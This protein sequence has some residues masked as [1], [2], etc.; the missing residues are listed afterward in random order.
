M[1]HLLADITPVARPNLAAAMREKIEEARRQQTT[2]AGITR[3][4]VRVEEHAPL[5]FLHWLAAL[6]T[7]VLTGVSKYYWSDRTRVRETAA[8]DIAHSVTAHT[9]D[10]LARI[11]DTLETSLHGQPDTVRYFGGFRFDLNWN[12]DTAGSP[13]RTF[14]T[15][16]FVLPRFELIRYADSLL[17]AC[18]LCESDW[19]DSSLKHIFSTLDALPFVDPPVPTPA[20]TVLDRHDL[21]EFD[22]WQSTLRSVDEMFARRELQKIVLARQS[23]LTFDRPLS[24]WVLLDQL[25]AGSD[26]CYL[27]GMQ[28]EPGTAF[29]GSSPEQL[30]RRDGVRLRTEAVAGTRPRGGTT[31][32]DNRL[33]EALRTSEKDAREHRVVLEGIIEALTRLDIRYKHEPTP[34]VRS[35]SRVHH[36]TCPIIG[37][38]PESTTDRDL[39]TALHPTPAVGGYPKASALAQIR[40]L[41]PFDRGWYAGPIG[42]IGSTGAE[43]AVGIRSALIDQTSLHLFAGAGIVPGSDPESEWREVDTK[44]SRFI[45]A[46]AGSE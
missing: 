22:A 8:V 36:L 46:V 6:E 29:V 42:W 37:K 28:T 39:I 33:A 32:E 5:N 30:Y 35:L 11:F 7:G 13:W 18:N 21:P 41:E 19:R 38:L 27:F 31:E 34:S 9:H 44:M 3:I 14:P 1:S 17:F 40:L 24:P 25:Q 23:T 16:R 2:T 12:R 10:D 4:T 15:A 26:G 43:F 45:A 20:P